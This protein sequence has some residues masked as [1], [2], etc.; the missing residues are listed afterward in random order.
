MI[1]KLNRYLTLHLGKRDVTLL[2]TNAGRFWR[3]S[4]FVTVKNWTFSTVL[5]YTLGLTLVFT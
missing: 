5:D 4:R 2:R 3:D 1:D